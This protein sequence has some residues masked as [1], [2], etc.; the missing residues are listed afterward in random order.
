MTHTAAAEGR[1]PWALR[2]KLEI[3]RVVVCV[4]QVPDGQ[5]ERRIE[6][7]RIVR[8]EDDSLNELDEFAIEAA[9]SLVEDQGGEVIAVSVGPEDASD[10]VLR[11]LQMGADRGLLV[12]DPSL[13]G[14]DAPATAA[15]LSAALAYLSQ[16]EPVDLVV[17]GMASLDGM[18]SLVPPALA[19]YAQL[20]YLGLAKSVSPVGD[21]VQALQ[22]RR[23]VDGWTETLQA[24]LPLVLSVTDQVNEPR[25]PS[26]KNLKAARQKPIEELSWDDLAEFGAAG[27]GER[28][29]ARPDEVMVAEPEGRSGPRTLIED[30]GDGGLRL[31]EFI[32]PHLADS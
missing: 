5:S 14:I 7:G 31:A 12:S 28:V 8:G 19:G 18:T 24:P 21:P 26:F 32:A 9:V 16:D 30:T 17:L 10:A 13:A 23:E 6:A 2:G 20:P 1:S 4:K 11:A 29:A 3:M 27:V 22:I 15:V 25:Y